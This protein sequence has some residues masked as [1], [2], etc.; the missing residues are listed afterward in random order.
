MTQCNTKTR[1]HF[2]SPLPV[3]VEFG[4]D[5][6]SAEGG[7]L[8]LRLAED[9]LGICETI[10]ALVPDAR[11]PARTRHSRH[12]QVLQRVLQIALGYADQNDADGL[13]DDPLLKTACASSP[14]GPALSSP[15]TLSR[16]ENAPD[17]RH[18]EAMQLKLITSW[19]RGLD[20]ER[21]EF[22][23]DVDSSAF[24][25]HGAQQHLSFCGFHRC[26]KLHPLLVFDDHTGQLVTV[27]L[28]PGRASDAQDAMKWLERIIVLLKSLHR[29]DCSVVVRADA[30]FGRP[31]IYRGLEEL[32]ESFGQ[33]GY[34]IGMA[35]NSVL[36]A[37]LE[38][39][40]EQARQQRQRGVRPARVFVDF[41][42]Q[43]G[44]WQRAR[45][46]VGKAEVT[47]RGDNPRFVVTNLEEFPARLLYEVGYCGRGRCEQ[48]IGEFKGALRADRISCHAFEANGF[49]LILHALAY[50]LLFEIRQTLAHQHRTVESD[51]SAE[52]KSEETSS[53]REQLAELARASFG[54]LRLQLLKVAFVVRQSV[55]RISLQGSKHFPRAD[56][57]HLVAVA[58]C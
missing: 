19:I 53:I 38:P 35:R 12:E 4:A 44:S 24:E 13:R 8:L 47:T 7:A 15:P 20:D 22:V 18:L 26:H 40:L 29:E 33:V 21:Q 23:L 37:R 51:G 3:D 25:G 50:R 52:E 41:K 42:Y 10:A 54:R 1:L 55:R 5:D 58:L 28:R 43:A 16:L 17:A 6:I 56:L 39:A 34:L 32:D 57:F 14:H 46:L 48:S 9:R 27:I 2:Q 49:R 45:H 11:D 36:Q 30:G 31:E